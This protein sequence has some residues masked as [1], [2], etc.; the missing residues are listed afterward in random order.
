[1]DAF[2]QLRHSQRHVL[3][4]N[5]CGRHELREASDG[6]RGGDGQGGGAGRR[7]GRKVSAVRGGNSG[8]A[9][10]ERRNDRAQVGESHGIADVEYL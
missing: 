1:M 8:L 2:H 4:A 3:L 7:S 5:R 9:E 10:R 6:D